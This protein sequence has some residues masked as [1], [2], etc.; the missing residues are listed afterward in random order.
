MEGLLDYANIF[1]F[2][3]F[4]LSVFW[5]LLNQPASLFITVAVTNFS[6]ILAAYFPVA[7]I[8]TV[9]FVLDAI[10]QILLYLLRSFNLMDLSVLGFFFAFMGIGFAF[11]FVVTIVQWILKALPFA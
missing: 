1:S 5:D 8:P 3:M 6:E 7:L 10:E 2:W 11:Y 9:Q 4:Q